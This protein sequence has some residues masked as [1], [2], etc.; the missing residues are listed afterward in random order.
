MLCFL[1]LALSLLRISYGADI[2]M[3][4]SVYAMDWWSSRDLWRQRGEG[5]E[6][7]EVVWGEEERRARPDG[8]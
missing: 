4:R 5:C 8:V 6:V 1:L 7:C 2:A 3:R